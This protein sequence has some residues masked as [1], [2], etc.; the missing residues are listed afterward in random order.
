L[1]DRQAAQDRNAQSAEAV[2][3]NVDGG[4]AARIGGGHA[5]SLAD[6]S[7]RTLQIAESTNQAVCCLGSASF[8]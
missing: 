6:L 8:P 3:E 5:T 4:H 2:T 7:R 1:T